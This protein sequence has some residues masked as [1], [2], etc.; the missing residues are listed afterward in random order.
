MPSHRWLLRDHGPRGTDR[1]HLVLVTAAVG[2][3]ALL[4]GIG[5]DGATVA[6]PPP[7]PL[8]SLV[9][10]QPLPGFTSAPVGPTDGPLTASEFASQSS[11]PT[12]AEQ[13]FDGLAAKPGFGAFIR[14]WTDRGGPGA[15]ANDL[16]VLLF[17]IGDRLAARSFATGLNQPFEGVHGST[18]FS[19]PS[20]PGA[21][22]Y[23]VV[24][25]A[26]VPAVEQVVVFRAGRYVSMVELASTTAAANPAPL[27]AAQAVAVSY[28]QHSRLRSGDPVGTTSATQV[29]SRRGP[30]PPVPATGSRTLLPVS[31]SALLVA[32]AVVV[33]VVVRRRRRPAPVPVPALPEGDHQVD[34]WGPDGVFAEFVGDGA[35]PEDPAPPEDPPSGALRSDEQVLATPPEPPPPMPVPTL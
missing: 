20:V 1:I 33:T 35:W 3:A 24:V 15:G 10:A 17:R 21:R 8:Q 2:I 23:S 11:N 29:A 26:P 14:L 13:Q 18:P 27:T 4:T 9:L 31:L 16:V 30:G 28:L 7:I 25:D 12:R 32:V 19:V 6:A 34:P 5:A 22:G